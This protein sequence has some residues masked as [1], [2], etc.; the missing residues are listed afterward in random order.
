MRKVIFTSSGSFAN[1]LMV[2]SMPTA[3]AKLVVP[4]RACWTT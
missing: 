4:M 2:R 3:W 1:E